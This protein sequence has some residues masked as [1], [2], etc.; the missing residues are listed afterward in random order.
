MSIEQRP[1]VQHV[2]VQKWRPWPWWKIPPNPLKSVKQ[3]TAQVFVQYH[4]TQIKPAV[5]NAAKQKYERG[6]TPVLHCRTAKVPCKMVELRWKLDK[7][8]KKLKLPSVL[9]QGDSAEAVFEPQKPIH[10][11]TFENCECLGRIA[12]MDWNDLI[13]QGKVVSVEYH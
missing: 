9:K 4:P 1:N 3:F 6:F 8:E 2:P 5:W 13:M 10:L 7:N 12:F 11:E